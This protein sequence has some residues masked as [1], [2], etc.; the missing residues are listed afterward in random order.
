MYVVYVARHVKHWVVVPC[1][2][3]MS[4]IY[5]KVYVVDVGLE[6]FYFGRVVQL[7]DFKNPRQIVVSSKMSGVWEVDKFHLKPIFQIFYN[8]DVTHAQI[9]DVPLMHPYA[10]GDQ[11]LVKK[12]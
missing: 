6:Q 1:V 12:M 10:R 9:D 7:M 11:F 4:R 5:V 3:Y 8:L 2:C